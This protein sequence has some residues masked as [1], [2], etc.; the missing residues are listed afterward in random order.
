MLNVAAP[1][2][3]GF[4]LYFIGHHPLVPRL[5]RNHLADGLW[6]YAFISSLLIIWNRE[7]N[8]TWMIIP[9]FIA[10]GF[11]SLQYY[12]KIEGTGDA[13]D[14]VTYWLFFMIPLKTNKFF[15]THFQT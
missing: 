5:V 11:E 1:L 9:F 12:G 2:L 15:K 3:L 4:L 7:M 14:M 8:T 10:A 6:A 13:Y